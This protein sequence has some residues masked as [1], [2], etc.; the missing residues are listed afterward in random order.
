MM[1]KEF[2]LT[3]P[4]TQH[5]EFYQYFGYITKIQGECLTVQGLAT[6]VVGSMVKIGTQYGEVIALTNATDILVMMYGY[7]EGIP[8]GAKV[9][10]WHRDNVIFPHTSW[11]GHVLN[12]WGQALHKLSKPLHQGDTAWHLKS[13][14]PASHQR[15]RVHHVCDTGIRALNTFTPLFYGQ[16]MGI[17]SGSGVG[18]STLLAQM[19]Q[20]TSCD[21]VVVGLI[22]ERGREVREFLE[23]HLT[24]HARKKSV[25]VVAT[26]DEPALMRRR[27]AYTTLSIAEYFRDQGQ[28]VLCIMD[29]VTRFAMAQRDI[30]LGRGEFPVTKG[31]PASVFTELSRLLERAGPGVQGTITGLFSVL[32]EGDDFNDALTDMIRSILDGHI[33]LSRAIAHR[34]RFPAIDVLKSVSRMALSWYDESQTSIISTCKKWLSLYEDMEDIIRMGAYSKGQ[35]SDVDYAITKVNQ[36]EDFFRQPWG[37]LVNVQQSFQHLHSIVYGV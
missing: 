22:G 17:F 15:L 31:Y 25:V 13:A 5:K 21:V 34:G 29:S 8:L 27:A 36:L 3:W 11:K 28:N 2:G 12:A 24:T 32:V 23:D 33:V 30:G 1:F 26:S 6:A 16:R 9:L 4:Y 37:T 7:A 20:A 19:I 35:S 18:K 14:P 10:L